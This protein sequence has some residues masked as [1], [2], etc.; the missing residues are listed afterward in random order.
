MNNEPNQNDNKAESSS[1]SSGYSY[2][3]ADFESYKA[4]EKEPAQGLAIASMA[5]G[6]TSV[7]F[8]LLLCCCGGYVALIAWVPALA[9]IV[10]SIIAKKL[11]N[12]SGFAT[13]GLIS[14]IIMLALMALFVVAVILFYVVYILF[15]VVFG[16]M[17]EVAALPI[18]LIATL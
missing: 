7:A 15:V 14:G 11:G 2:S 10:M 8:L 5:C 16:V 13:I 1:F 3:A 6:L 9:A 17:G 18:S 4:N 12:R